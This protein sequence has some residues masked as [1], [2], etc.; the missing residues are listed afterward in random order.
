MFVGTGVSTGK[1]VL[2]AVAV[3]GGLVGRVGN[4]G[5]WNRSK[6]AFSSHVLSKL[7]TSKKVRPG[8]R[9]KGFPLRS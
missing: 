1:G 7:T 6:F 4:G 8:F 3:L 9:G 5:L 2:V